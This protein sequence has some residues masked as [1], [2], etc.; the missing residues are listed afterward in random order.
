MF[1]FQF[2]PPVKTLPQC[3][4]GKSNDKPQ[5]SLGGFLLN[6]KSCFPNGYCLLQSFSQYCG[7]KKVFVPDSSVCKKTAKFY[8]ISIPIYDKLVIDD[9]VMTANTTLIN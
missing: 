7:D 1:S 5:S 8:I 3:L 4:L 6:K 2:A 9:T